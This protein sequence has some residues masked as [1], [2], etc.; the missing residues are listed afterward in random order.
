[1]PHDL[2]GLASDELVDHFRKV[3]CVAGLLDAEPQANQEEEHGEQGKDDQLKGQR[4]ADWVTRIR[5]MNAQ[6][7]EQ[8]IQ[9]RREPV[10]QQVGKKIDPGKHF[11]L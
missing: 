11:G 8:K 6:L 10:I 5:G 7:P 9:G 1:V 3:L 4:V 2:L